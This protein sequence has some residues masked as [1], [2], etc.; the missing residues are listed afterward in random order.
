MPK[1]KEIRL[2]VASY[3]ASGGPGRVTD[4]NRANIATKLDVYAGTPTTIEGQSNIPPNSHQSTS[5]APALKSQNKHGSKQARQ[6]NLPTLSFILPNRVAPG[7]VGENF[8]SATRR[9]GT[10]EGRE[11]TERGVK[12]RAGDATTTVQ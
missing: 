8:D 6:H 12:K 5:H 11:N 7:V 3:K 9:A 2:I 4:Y 1:A 10:H